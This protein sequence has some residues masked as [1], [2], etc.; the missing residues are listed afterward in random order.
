MEGHIKTFISSIDPPAM[1]DYRP[2]N[3][4][5]RLKIDVQR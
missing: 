4:Q 3:K 5:I 2:N 1:E